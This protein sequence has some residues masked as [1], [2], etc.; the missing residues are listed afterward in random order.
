MWRVIHGIV[1]FQGHWRGYH[2][3]QQ[4]NAKM[5]VER[6]LRR[7]IVQHRYKV[8]Q[9]QQK[10]LLQQEALK[11]QSP[12]TRQKKEGG[13]WSYLVKRRNS[14]EAKRPVPTD[15]SPTTTSTGI[16]PSLG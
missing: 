16:A 10:R 6:Q 12:P 9:E 14:T 4:N 13:L 2:L 11:N 7:F 3:R 1:L 8:S 15:T 5:I